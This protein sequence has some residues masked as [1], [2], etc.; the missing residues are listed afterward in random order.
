MPIYT[1]LLGTNA[2]IVERPL[3]NGFKERIQVPPDPTTL[4]RIADSS[5]GQFFETTNAQSLQTVY[6]RLASKLGHRQANTEVTA[7]FAGI[8]GVLLPAGRGALGAV[9]PEGP[10]RRLLLVA[11]VL[12]A[13]GAAPGRA[14]AAR[15]CQGLMVCIPVAGPWVAVPAPS[16][17]VAVPVQF[18]LT[19]PRG[20]VVAGTDALVSDRALDVEFLGTVGAPVGP[21]VTTHEA[22]LFIGTYTAPRNGRRASSR[23]SAACRCR[24]AAGARRP[25]STRSRPGRSRPASPWCG[26]RRSCS[27][28]ST[29]PPPAPPA[30][31]AAS[32]SSARPMRSRSHR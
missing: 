26:G 5:G 16:G 9:V 19:C 18:L 12:A 22:V 6:Q 30:A 7:G 23:T 1:V 21:G 29:G 3:A 28:R 8:A 13:A 11:L 31:T 2:G 24:A 20:S 4:R 15:E 25:R 27:S 14:D 17:T 10:V 32:G